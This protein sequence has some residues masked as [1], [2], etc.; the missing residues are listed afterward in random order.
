[1]ATGAC[2]PYKGSGGKI[3]EFTHQLRW[4]YRIESDADF[5]KTFD[6]AFKDTKIPLDQMACVRDYLGESKHGMWTKIYCPTAEGVFG[7]YSI[8]RT[9][10][11]PNEKGSYWQTLYRICPDGSLI[12]AVTITNVRDSDFN[13]LA[14]QIK[15]QTE[16]RFNRCIPIP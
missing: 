16:L 5:V 6:D 12:G 1:M 11:S 14:T 3:N 10:R 9:N 2:S 8:E 4:N 15:N 7:S 13:D